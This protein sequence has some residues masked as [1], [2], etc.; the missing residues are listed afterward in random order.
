METKESH[1]VNCMILSMK[2]LHDS[3]DLRRLCII[4]HKKIFSNFLIILLS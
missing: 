1:D 4:I 3:D 2:E